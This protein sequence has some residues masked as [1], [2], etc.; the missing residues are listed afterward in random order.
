M[1]ILKSDIPSADSPGASGLA[2][3]A[4]GKFTGAWL[5]CFLVMAQS[6]GMMPAFS[7]DHM[8]RASMCG[9]VGAVLTVV[10]LVQM[11][12][13]T[14]SLA[15]QMTI[16]AVVTFIG[17]V[18]AHPSHFPPQ[19]AEPLVT[20]AVSAG[21]AI[22]VWYATRWAKALMAMWAGGSATP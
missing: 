22:A 11:D 15:R 16:S 12:R 21:I 17:D 20:A 19:W 4:A 5:S 8:L 13:A 7:A 1:T 14:N 6:D 3:R 9:T 10:L 18:F 2:L